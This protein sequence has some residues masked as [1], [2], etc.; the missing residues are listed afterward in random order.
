[1]KLGMRF[2]V[3][4][5]ALGFAVALLAG[6]ALAEPYKGATPPDADIIMDNFNKRSKRWIA[7][8]FIGKTKI[9]EFEE[10]WVYYFKVRAVKG[11]KRGFEG[12]KIVKLDNNKW[13][14]LSMSSKGLIEKP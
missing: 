10:A 8:E 9:S 1:M 3:I 12:I 2:T 11:P 5:L 7:D 14:Q 6:T 4:M 13:L